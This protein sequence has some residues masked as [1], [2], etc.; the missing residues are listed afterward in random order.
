MRLQGPVIEIPEG[1]SLNLTIVMGA[2]LM[3]NLR[4][5][6]HNPNGL[7]PGNTT[8]GITNPA[9]GLQFL[10]R[11]LDA[12]TQAQSV[13]ASRRGRLNKDDVELEAQTEGDIPL[14]DMVDDR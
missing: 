1:F 6:Y 10:N 14:E 2:R 4:E 8:A 9:A 3:L 7:A 11:D 13:F 5:T 12:E